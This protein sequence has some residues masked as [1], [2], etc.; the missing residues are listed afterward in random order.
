MFDV[1]GPLHA[2]FRS[3]V[4]SAYVQEK[5]PVFVSKKI[6]TT[7]NDIIEVQQTRAE[8]VYTPLSVRLAI[9]YQNANIL[10]LK[11]DRTH[12]TIASVMLPLRLA[13]TEKE[14]GQESGCAR[15]PLGRAVHVGQTEKLFRATFICYISVILLSSKRKSSWRV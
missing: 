8:S 14:V 2:R 6:R 11:R 7:P 5:R 4:D 3:H 9:S 13:L 10:D 15:S 1:E 12:S